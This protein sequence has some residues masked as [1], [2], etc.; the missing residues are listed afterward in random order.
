MVRE[1]VDKNEWAIILGGSSGLGFA[2]AQKL[3][4]H[5]MNLILIYRIPR[6]KEQA[7]Q[8]GFEELK[9]KNIQ[10]KCFNINALDATKR[11]KLIEDLKTQIGEGK[12]KALIHSIAK[13]SLKPMVSHQKNNVLDNTD[14][15]ITLQA[16]ALSLFDWVKD[17]F[18]ARMFCDD[19]R[20]LSFT[21]EGNQKV[22]PNYAAVSAA[23]AALEAISRNIAFAFAPHNITCNCIQAGITDTDSL[24]MIPGSD[25]LKEMTLKRNPNKRLTRPEDIA[26]VVY[27]LCKD[28]A[29]WINGTVIVADGGEHLN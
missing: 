29:K 12:I 9:K 16:M 6:S 25:K 11:T 13:G 3:A 2:T 8:E 26:N 1:F 19:A 15:D 4:S 23:K 18:Q 14:F 22:W 27:L 7:L 20:I 21:S 24:N 10:F 17:L 5:G 28:E